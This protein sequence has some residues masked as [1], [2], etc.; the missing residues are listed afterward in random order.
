MPAPDPLIRSDAGL[1]TAI[2]GNL[3]SGGALSPNG[4]KMLENNPVLAQDVARVIEQSTGAD[5][6]YG[7]NN[8]PKLGAD[9]LPISTVPIVSVPVGGSPVLLPGESVSTVPAASDEIPWYYYAAGAG[10][11]FL[12]LARRKK[13]RR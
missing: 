10:A 6:T 3:L 9:G 7:T 12:I 2:A 1:A 11:L 5:P 8:P 4:A 13:K